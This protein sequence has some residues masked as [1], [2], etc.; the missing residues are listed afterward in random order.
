MARAKPPI[1]LEADD[2]GRDIQATRRGLRKL[3]RDSHR[4]WL[5]QDCR[6]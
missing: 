1:V 4:A 3:G 5:R 2:I 6:R